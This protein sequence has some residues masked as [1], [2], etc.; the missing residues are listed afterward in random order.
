MRLFA[1]QSNRMPDGKKTDAADKT[2]VFRRLEEIALIA[3]KM[4]APTEVPT[5]AEPAASA[6]ELA[7]ARIREETAQTLEQAFEQR[8]ATRERDLQAEVAGVIAS[9]IESYKASIRRQDDILRG[10]LAAACERLL[11]AAT[12]RRA[13]ELIPTDPARQAPVRVTTGAGFP[14]TDLLQLLAGRQAARIVEI[15]TTTALAPHQVLIGW[16]PGWAEIDGTAWLDGLRERLTPSEID[17][18]SISDLT[19]TQ[20]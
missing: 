7:C 5:E 10:V 6:L 11:D 14:G 20:A 17:S 1:R 9:I 15:E 2:A 8:L 13:I 3:A 4:Q 19:T 12:A 18:A 16:E